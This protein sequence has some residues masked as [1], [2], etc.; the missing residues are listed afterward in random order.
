MKRELIL[1]VYLPDEE[2]SRYST[3]CE[4]AINQFG[5][6]AVELPIMNLLSIIDD[7]NSPPSTLYDHTFLDTEKK[8]SVIYVP[9]F[10]LRACRLCKDQ[11]SFLKQERMPT[12][13]RFHDF[14][15]IY[16]AGPKDTCTCRSF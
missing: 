8:S 9:N 7:Y 6:H 2:V 11:L 12:F 1:C 15:F 4:D 13:I 10:K 16:I 14:S 3:A 5:H